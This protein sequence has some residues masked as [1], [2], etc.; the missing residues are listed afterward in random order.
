LAI[1][2]LGVGTWLIYV[3]D[4]LLDGHSARR[5]PL[6]H[7]LRERHFFHARHRRAFLIAATAAAI[8]LLW[9]I[10]IMPPAARFEDTLLFAVSMVYFAIV[11]LPFIRFPKSF[12]PE[13]A[14]GILF[15]CATAIPAWSQTESPHAVLLLSIL[16]FGGLCC[17]NCL[18]IELWE[19]PIVPI[20][21]LTIPAI[22]FCVAA[23]SSALML[24]VRNS[25]SIRLSA[26][27]LVSALLILALDRLHRR[28]TQR[29]PSQEETAGFLLAMR[30]AADAALLTPLLFALPWH[31]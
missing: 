17:L 22:A 5:S 18:A 14:V 20:R 15:A 3:A 25:I 29:G 7:N 10:S 6:N 23:A 2:V 30:V 26:A 27:A 24:T 13:F 11:H 1:T 8:V 19:R 4:R 12:P 28:F 31:V 21:Q 9:L 16:L